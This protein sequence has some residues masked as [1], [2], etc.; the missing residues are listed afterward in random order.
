MKAHVR[1]AAEARC[2]NRCCD[3]LF[4]GN[5]GGT[6][7]LIEGNPR[8]PLIQLSGTAVTPVWSA[9]VTYL[10]LNL[11]GLFMPLRVIQRV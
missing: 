11:G 8:L 4:V 10:L 5:T 1:R 3:D 2:A 7:G 6:S 9:G